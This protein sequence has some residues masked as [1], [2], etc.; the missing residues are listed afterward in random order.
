VHIWPFLI[1]HAET[2]K[3]IQ[4]CE[5]TFH[6]PGEF[7]KKVNGLRDA[8]N[9]W[10][11]KV[12]QA[13]I[14]ATTIQDKAKTGAPAEYQTY[15]TAAAEAAR[16]LKAVL[17]RKGRISKRRQ[18]RTATCSPRHVPMT[19]TDTTVCY[20]IG[21]RDGSRHSGVTADVYFSLLRGTSGLSQ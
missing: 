16:M 5:G 20:E 8:E 19:E 13:V 10:I 9:A 4:P 12:P 15:I 18:Y 6:N 7:D 17:A 11:G 1:P 2:A 21:T 14:T 3:L